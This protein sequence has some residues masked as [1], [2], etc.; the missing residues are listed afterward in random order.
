MAEACSSKASLDPYGDHEGPLFYEADGASP[1][2]TDGKDPLPP[3]PYCAMNP[4]VRFRTSRAVLA[5][6]VGAGL[7]ALL[8]LVVPV[9]GVEAAGSTRVPRFSVQEKDLN[10]DES[11]RLADFL[12]ARGVRIVT[13][14]D[15]D[16][17][18]P[19]E[20][21]ARIANAS[22]ADLFVSVH[23]NGSFDR[24]QRG[25]EIYH[26]LGSDAGRRLAERIL[27]GLTRATGFPPG[28]V[29]SRPGEHGDYYFLLRNVNT[30]SLIVEGGYVSSPDEAPALADPEVRQKMAEAI[31]EAVLEQFAA[32]VRRGPGPPAPLLDVPLAGPQTVTSL[33][34]PDNRAELG[35]AG[36]AV[37]GMAYSVWRDGVRVADIP[38]T[39]QARLAFRDPVPL[40]PGSHR[41]EVQASLSVGGLVA[42]LSKAVPVD[43]S[44]PAV[45]VVDAGHGG[46]DPGAIG[47]R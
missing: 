2:V 20:D 45:V 38:A 15:S 5:S 26:Q 37:P 44:R 28:G 8:A 18:V 22:S 3:R 1:L 11:V 17:F 10:L 41:Y 46:N 13:T 14:R 30:L 9:S 27:A 25:V 42:A 34:S 40:E 7:A 32:D 23:N 21:R 24:A 16:V 33:L 19:L 47:P 12:S 29:F 43:A 6:A 39:G 31:G 4:G 36:A 35:W